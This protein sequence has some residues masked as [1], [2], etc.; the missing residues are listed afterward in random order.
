M[1]N[2]GNIN[3]C[4]YDSDEFIGTNI[5]SCSSRH[6]EKDSNR[7][8]INDL[9]LDSS[10]KIN[11][12]FVNKKVNNNILSDCEII[13]YDNSNEIKVSKSSNLNE[14]KNESYKQSTNDISSLFYNN[15]E[16]FLDYNND[17]SDENFTVY[18]DSSKLKKCSDVIPAEKKKCTKPQNKNVSI[19]KIQHVDI[20][21]E[22][23]SKIIDSFRKISHLIQYYVRL[24]EE[25]K[26]Q[27]SEMDMVQSVKAC[28]ETTNSLFTYIKAE[29]DKN[30]CFILDDKYH[31]REGYSLTNGSTKIYYIEKLQ[32]KLF[33][34]GEA[35]LGFF[36][37][38]G[39][40]ITYELGDTYIEANFEGDLFISLD[41]AK[42]KANHF[43]KF[44]EAKFNKVTTI[45]NL[46][47][48]YLD[49]YK[50]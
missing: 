35:I 32:M 23:L 43:N 4:D 36:E 31:N 28:C 30:K 6:E 19:S 13:T 17:T 7:I 10:Q 24:L 47:L 5:Y 44:I 39:R 40:I 12:H 18:F 38:N 16:N 37:D 2:L 15:S 9:D 29:I 41:L 49:K 33:E 48:I 1:S 11:N 50:V 8:N 25:T 21:T 46:Q 34:S 22:K 20:I 26:I 42:Q 3:F 27:I 45:Y 14:N